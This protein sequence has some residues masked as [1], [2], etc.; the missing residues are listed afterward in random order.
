[1]ASAE[2]GQEVIDGDDPRVLAAIERGDAYFLEDSPRKSPGAGN[3]EAA[4]IEP[5]G[6]SSRNG[7]NSRDF[8]FRTPICGIEFEVRRDGKHLNLHLYEEGQVWRFEEIDEWLVTRLELLAS[9]ARQV[10]G[11]E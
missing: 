10:L 7:A 9:C 3:M 2:E 11:R 4:G 6:E 1:V 8:S 5:A